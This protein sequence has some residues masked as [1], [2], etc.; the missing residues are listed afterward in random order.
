M[1]AILAAVT[2]GATAEVETLLPS[3]VDV[4]APVDRS[5]ATLLHHA[6]T[7]AVVKKLL[8]GNADPGVTESR[9]GRTPLHNAA[10]KGNTEVGVVLAAA[11]TAAQILIQEKGGYYTA[12]HQAAK[13]GDVLLV[14][15][16][17]KYLTAEQ[18]MIQDEQEGV[19]ALHVAALKG[20]HLVCTAIVN[21]AGSAL[22]GAVNKGGMTALHGAA[23]HG[24]AKVCSVL[25][26]AM[27]S[28]DA[29][30]KDP[31]GK[32]ALFYAASYKHTE[33]CA[34]LARAVPALLAT[35]DTN[36]GGTPLHHAAAHGYDEVCTVLAGAM[37]VAQ[38]GMQNHKSKTAMDLA[39]D[40]HRD[41]VV[42]TIANAAQ[43]SGAPSHPGVSAPPSR[44]PDGGN[45]GSP[46]STGDPIYDS[47]RSRDSHDADPESVSPATGMSV[48]GM[49]SEFTK[50]VVS[51]ASAAVPASGL[52]EIADDRIRRLRQ[53]ADSSDDVPDE[54]ICH[55]TNE[56]MEDPVVAMD[57]HTYEKVAIES[58]YAQHQTSPITREAVQTVL[59]PNHSM[60]SQ[61]T[62]WVD[63]GGKRA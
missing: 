11:M 4:S 47:A 15:E 3:I 55:I 46:G 62:A 35:A 61:I 25:A 21:K 19:T 17:M 45:P 23:R 13:T 1:E 7:S 51:G 49:S 24:H 59:I 20:H 27:P 57:G 58:W 16:L 30:I 53:V 36:T 43:R 12:L 40:N 34:V 28:E 22:L 52:T 63:H 38:L 10:V 54:F 5:G 2:S 6:S 31:I 32:T 9:W 48:A 44:V 14:K 56:V 37:T 33:A 26:A 29:T 18:A 41:E 39:R 60:R 50:A 8:A 42:E